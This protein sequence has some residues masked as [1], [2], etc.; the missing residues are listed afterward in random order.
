M[1]NIYFFYFCGIPMF[2]ILKY[3]QN[4][5]F[6]QIEDKDYKDGILRQKI[7]KKKQIWVLYGKF[8]IF[9]LYTAAQTC[10]HLKSPL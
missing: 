2:F 10:F 8:A 4:F 1:T 6:S 3:F 7:S 9:V 5:I